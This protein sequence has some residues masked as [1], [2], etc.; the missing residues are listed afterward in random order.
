MPMF[1]IQQTELSTGL[2][3]SEF[4]VSPHQKDILE[5]K[6]NGPGNANS[7]NEDSQW[8][9]KQFPHEAPPGRIGDFLLIFLLLLL[10][11]VLLIVPDYDFLLLLLHHDDITR[12]L[13]FFTG[14]L[15]L[16]ILNPFRTKVNVFVVVGFCVRGYKVQLRGAL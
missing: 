5:D 2:G 10:L 12:L 9:H 13:L 8:A 7:L 4:A 1:E 11:Q 16:F 6:D 3:I 14:T 15:H